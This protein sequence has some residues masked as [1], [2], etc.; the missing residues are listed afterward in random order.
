VEG[1]IGAAF[2]ARS[3]ETTVTTASGRLNK[4]SQTPHPGNGVPR[5]AEP[6]AALRKARFSFTSHI[7]PLKCSPACYTNGG[8]EVLSS[9][10][11]DFFNSENVN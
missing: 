6:P 10:M 8:R 7:W 4:T 9:D 3:D 1:D 2:S 11:K 5:T